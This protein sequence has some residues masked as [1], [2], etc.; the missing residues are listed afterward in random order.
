MRQITRKEV[1]AVLIKALKPQDFSLA[2]WEQGAAS[3]GRIDQWSDIDMCL[4]VKDNKVES[5]FKVVEKALTKSFGIA[6][7]FRLPEPAWHG[8]SQCF[9]R[10]KGASPFLFVDLAV[11][12]ASSKDKFLQFDIHGEPATLFDKAG[13]VRNDKIDQKEFAKKLEARLET[14]KLTFEMFQVEVLKEM[15]RGNYMEA[16]PFYHGMTLRPLVEVLRIKHCPYRFNFHTRYVYFDLPPSVVKRLHRFVFIG[17]SEVLASRHGE[18][19][20]WF[21]EIM[22]SIKAS[23]IKRSLAILGRDSEKRKQ[24]SRKAR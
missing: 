20:K 19:G 11:M 3:F 24:K 8:Q 7:K 13:I 12:K 18:A 17:S 4:V 5:A 23:D 15:N 9:Y 16:L 14:L 10:L 21:W 1:L 2:L 6:L 22:E